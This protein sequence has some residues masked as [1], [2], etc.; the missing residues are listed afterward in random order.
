M[1]ETVFGLIF[2]AI[3]SLASELIGPASSVTLGFKGVRLLSEIRGRFMKDKFYD[4]SWEQTWSVQ[5]TNFERENSSPLKIYRFM[6][7]LAGEFSVKSKK[8]TTHTIRVV[9]DIQGNIVTGRWSDPEHNAY[10]GTFQLVI[11][12]LGDGM[13]GKWIGFSKTNLVRADKIVWR[14]K[15]AA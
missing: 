13:E 1:F 5:S 10:Y 14:F 3:G 8:G 2:T 6:K 7:R 11:S 4:G 9:G 15:S 12:P